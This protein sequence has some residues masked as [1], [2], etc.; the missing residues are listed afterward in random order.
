MET[1]LMT[2]RQLAEMLATTRESISRMLAA[3]RLPQPSRLAG[4]RGLRWSRAEVM[5]WVE[6]GMPGRSEW[7]QMRAARR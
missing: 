7:E 2:T 4:G 5:A 6:A 1:V 3:G